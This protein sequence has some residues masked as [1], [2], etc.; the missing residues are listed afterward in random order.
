M[1]TYL[2]NDF[3]KLI[4]FSFG[5]FANGIISKLTSCNCLAIKFKY[6]KLY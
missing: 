2:S 6:D 1:R 3:N 5:Y 4:T